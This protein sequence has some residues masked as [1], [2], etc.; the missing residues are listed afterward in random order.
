V[1]HAV[2]LERNL[3]PASLRGDKNDVRDYLNASGRKDEF[4]EL[5]GYVYGRR[6]DIATPYPGVTAFIAAA[7]RAGYELFVI[8]HKTR[9]P[10]LGPAYDLHL[11]ALSFLEANG[12]VGSR[13]HQIARRDTYFEPTKE[14]KVARAAA[15][16]VDVFVEDLPEI[17]AAPGWP[18]AMRGILFD[19]DSR[20][21]DGIWK[22]RRFERHAHW[23]AIG[24]ALLSPE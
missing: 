7:R 20:F 15:L 2:A 9:V 12:I 14:E 22:N 3:I 21:P 19:P 18:N 10:I 23:D 16:K 6:M 24:K 17:L 4:T 11:A 5:Q 1:F 8:S 13:D